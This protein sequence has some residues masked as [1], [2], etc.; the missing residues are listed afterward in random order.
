MNKSIELNEQQVDFL[1]SA[2]IEITEGDY[3]QNSKVI[4]L[5]IINK[6]NEE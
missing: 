4:A 3:S 5:S 1:K 6:L 2:L